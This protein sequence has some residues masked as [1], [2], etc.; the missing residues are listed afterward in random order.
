MLAGQVYCVGGCPSTYSRVT[1][2]KWHFSPLGRSCSAT[3]DS[4]TLNVGIQLHEPPAIGIV[5]HPAQSYT[6]NT[7]SALC[8]AASTQVYTSSKN[9]AINLFKLQSRHRLAGWLIYLMLSAADTITGGGHLCCCRCLTLGMS[10]GSGSSGPSCCSRCQNSS[11]SAG[12]CTQQ[13]DRDS[14][15]LAFKAMSNQYGVHADNVWC[16]QCIFCTCSA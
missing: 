16:T 14:R 11:A 10:S 15:K 3:D 1:P 12:N 2:F 6:P 13:D 5:L 8:D 7:S 9:G 4:I